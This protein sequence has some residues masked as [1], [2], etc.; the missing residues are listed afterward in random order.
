MGNELTYV[1]IA[2]LSA[3][4]LLLIVFVL[5]YLK[6]LKVQKLLLLHITMA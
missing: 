4:G 5:L 1:L 2:L 6:S 3:F